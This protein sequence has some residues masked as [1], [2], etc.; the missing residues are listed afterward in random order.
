[1]LVS[2]SRWARLAAA[3]SLGLAVLSTAEIGHAQGVVKN[4]YGDWQLRCETPAGA[5]AEQCAIVQNV[6][7]EDRPNVT[8]VV[9][10]L[11]T[12]DGK[13]R[14]LRVI[15]PLGVLLPSGLGLKIDESDIG[16]AGFVRCLAYGCVA[17]VVM[18]DT[19]IQQMKIGKNATFIVFQTPEEGIGI[20]VSLNGFAAG[21][22][23]LP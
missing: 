1:M 17:E 12:A 5:K 19:L 21:F 10:V 16:R 7:A 6:A 20:P 22:D 8:L 14:L 23:A 11:K 18:E 2:M 3:L 13:S 9:I 15:A 4:T